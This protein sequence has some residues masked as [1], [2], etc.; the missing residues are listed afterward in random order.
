M[1]KSTFYS[2]V[3]E[4]NNIIA[5]KQDG[6]N[7]EYF[8]YY[9]RTYNNGTKTWFAIE[10]STGLSVATASTRKE[11]Q[12]KAQFAYWWTYRRAD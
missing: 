10:P 2:L 4:K 9:C 1:K 6:Y 7:D 12:Q 3:M 8:S 11:A 5:K